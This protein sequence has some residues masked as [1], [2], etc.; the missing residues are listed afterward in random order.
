MAYREVKKEHAF[1]VF[2]RQLREDDFEPV[3]FMRGEEEYLIEWACNSLAG[4]YV[5]KTMRDVDF[6]KTADEENVEGLLAACDTFSVFSE[7]RIV[8]ARNFQPLLKKTAK[9]FG[10][11]ELAAISEYITNPNPQTIL[12]FSCAQPEEGSPLVKELKSRCRTYTFDKLDRTQLEAFAAKRF[13]AAGADIDRSTIR[14]LI[15]ETGYFNR[16]TEYRLFNLENDIRKVCDYC[17]GNPIT[18]EDI[19]ST[20]KGDMDRF[21]FD[22]LDAAVSGKKD[23]ALSMLGN[24][25]G[26]GGEIY[27]LLGLLINQFELMLE[28]KEISEMTGSRQQAA[29]VLKVN[30][31]RVKKALS[32]ADKFSIKKLKEILVQLYETDRNIKTGLIEQN[33]ALELLMGR[34]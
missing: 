3:V 28:A 5:E 1:Q 26:G 17:W 31:Y 10:E 32:F 14:Y 30:P 12:V 33:L 34:I 16:D 6:I 22:F 11:R 20:V 2:S 4:K 7:K 13:R 29:E 24:I 25:L 21:V 8:W 23:K 9:G 18:E 19:D 15:D 27:S